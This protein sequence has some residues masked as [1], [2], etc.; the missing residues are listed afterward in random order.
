MTNISLTKLCNTPGI[1]I[2]YINKYKY[3]KTDCLQYISGYGIQYYSALMLC[4]LHNNKKLLKYLI[5][6]YDVAKSDILNIDIDH[7]YNSIH[8]CCFY[9][10]LSIFKYLINKYN[11]NKNDIMGI[12]DLNIIKIHY[13][14]ECI[15]CSQ[16]KIFKYIINKFNVTKDEILIK[17][18]HEIELLYDNGIDSI[19]LCCMYN[20]R[21]KILKYII[22]KYSI[23]LNTILNI[24]CLDICI[25]YYNHDALLYFINKYKISINY[26]YD[27]YFLTPSANINNLSYIM[28]QFYYKFTILVFIKKNKYKYNNILDFIY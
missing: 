5:K 13:I 18:I 15:H 6:T 27:K 1:S 4:C 14:N 24:N 10:R 28:K 20:N 23:S 2:S 8:Y 9:G 12:Y 22:K 3:T 19:Q 7:K 25:K 26:V 17:N 16:F 21:L 11:I